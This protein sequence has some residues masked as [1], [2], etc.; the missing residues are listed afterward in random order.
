MLQP[1]EEPRP[2]RNSQGTSHHLV[3]DT[4]IMHHLK[5]D[6][7]LKSVIEDLAFQVYLPRV[8]WN[9]LKHQ[10]RNN[11]TNF[12][13]TAQFIMKSLDEITRQG[14]QRRFTLQLD[15][16]FFC[17]RQRLFNINRVMNRH[18][19]TSDFN[20]QLV[21]EYALNIKS[22]RENVVLVTNDNYLTDL[23]GQKDVEVWNYDRLNKIMKRG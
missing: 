7:L 8:V 22:K 1:T 11:E 19:I 18:M 10:K 5:D 21:L 14:Q 17:S 20:D 6:E 9:E 23:A 4:N 15:S 16:E 3:L 12:G 13:K 2:K